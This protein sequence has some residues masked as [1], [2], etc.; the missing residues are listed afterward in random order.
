LVAFGHYSKSRTARWTDINPPGDRR[1]IATAQARD[2]FL[3]S[4]N[5]HIHYEQRSESTLLHEH[6]AAT[7]AARLDKKKMYF[8]FPISEI[9]CTP[10]ASADGLIRM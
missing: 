6:E 1:W 10:L 4:N 7:Y 2:F 3:N 8:V 5:K 9:S